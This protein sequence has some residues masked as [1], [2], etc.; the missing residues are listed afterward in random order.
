MSQK[1]Q[2][3]ENR[4]SHRPTPFQGKEPKEREEERVEGREKE[5]DKKEKEEE[6]KK[7]ERKET[8]KA[9]LKSFSLKHTAPS[10]YV[11]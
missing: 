3:R 7:E 6:K 9:G 10:E 5:R 1:L 2:L 4:S 11:P 8:E